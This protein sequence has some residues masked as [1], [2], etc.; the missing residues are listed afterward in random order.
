MKE[1]KMPTTARELGISDEIAI[2]ALA[3]AKDV[4]KRYTILDEK[5]IDEQTAREI[6]STVGIL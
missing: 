2:K 1:L 6:L 5:N 4:R 3:G